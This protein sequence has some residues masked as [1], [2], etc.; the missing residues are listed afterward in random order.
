LVA[1]RTSMMFPA[2]S[3]N[4][5]EGAMDISMAKRGDAGPNR[6]GDPS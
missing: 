4:S 2:A 3:T 5:A 1:L 6:Y